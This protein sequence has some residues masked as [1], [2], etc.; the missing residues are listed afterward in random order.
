MS[1]DMI[2]NILGITVPIILV[3]SIWISEYR[4]ELISSAAIIGITAIALKSS[5]N[6]TS[7]KD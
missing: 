7:S 3:L 5:I 6:K 1:R 4:I 2:S